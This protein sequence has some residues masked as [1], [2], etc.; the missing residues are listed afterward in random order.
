MDTGFL[1]PRNNQSTGNRSD[2]PSVLDIMPER[3]SSPL[4]W[5]YRFTAPTPAPASASLQEREISRRG[6]LTSATLLVVILL[7][8]AAEPVAIFGSDKNLIFV[9]LIPVFIDII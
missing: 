4:R 8:L 6:R 3:D 1:A 7:V 9:L 5:W 2:T